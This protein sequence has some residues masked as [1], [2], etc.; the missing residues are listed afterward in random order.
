MATHLRNRLSRLELT[1]S[2]PIGR[3][4]TVRGV[5]TYADAMSVL[6]DRG[7]DVGRHDIVSH[8]PGSTPPDVGMVEATMS[9]E[10]WVELLAQDEALNSIKGNQHDRAA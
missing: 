3:F 9:P 5:E 4:I 6:R 8:E 10:F 7:V 1:A 2:G